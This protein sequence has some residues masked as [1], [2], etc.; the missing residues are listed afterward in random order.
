MKTFKEYY[1]NQQEGI[2][3]DL[4]KDLTKIIFGRSNYH[5][6]KRLAH[7]EKYKIAL[8]RLRELKNEV[9]KA[10]GWD[11][12]AEKNN[13]S[14]P[15]MRTTETGVQGIIKQWAADFAGISTKEFSKILDRN[16][17]YEEHGAGEWGTD[18]LTNKYKNDTPGQ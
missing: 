5:K 14:R 6:A 3:V 11:K 10:G 8:K 9:R 7:G 2:G 4:A 13:L 17:R 1:Q 12:W 18:E 15:G 16:T